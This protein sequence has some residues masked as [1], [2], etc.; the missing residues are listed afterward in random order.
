MGAGVAAQGLADVEH[1]TEGE[2]VQEDA[3]GEDLALE[4][5]RKAEDVPDAH[6]ANVSTCSLEKLC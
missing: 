2:H 1:N 5:V 6:I 4:V 3:T